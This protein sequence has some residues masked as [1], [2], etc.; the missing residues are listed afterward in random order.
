MEA[1]CLKSLFF[2]ILAYFET[3]RIV[4]FGIY[5]NTNFILVVFKL[6]RHSNL[7]RSDETQIWISLSLAT[8]SFT[9]LAKISR[10]LQKIGSTW[11]D[12]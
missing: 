12:I 6:V 10:N 1:I 9:I 4:K 11:M 8:K 3:Y 5:F 7:S 2:S